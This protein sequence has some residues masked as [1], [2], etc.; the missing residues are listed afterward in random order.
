MQSTQGLRLLGTLI[1]HEGGRLSGSGDP[2]MSLISLLGC[3]IAAAQIITTNGP[4]VPQPAND[5]LPDSEPLYIRSCTMFGTR[6]DVYGY[7]RKIV[8]LKFQIL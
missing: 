3:I 7:L 6:Y 8:I 4:N 2:I 1:I 5:G